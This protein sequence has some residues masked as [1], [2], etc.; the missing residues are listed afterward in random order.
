MFVPALAMDPLP[1]LYLSRII[2]FV[3]VTLTSH[4]NHWLH[5]QVA[6]QVN[7]TVRLS[8]TILTLGSPTLGDD[9]K[10]LFLDK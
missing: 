7:I 2:D 10:I 3:S 1:S 9:Y 6:I 8:A 5:L 4:P